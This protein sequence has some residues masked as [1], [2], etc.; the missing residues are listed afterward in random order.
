MGAGSLDPVGSWV[1]LRGAVLSPL[2]LLALSQL[3]PGSVELQPGSARPGD[4]VLV[5]VRGAHAEPRG[6]LG[7]DTLDFFE[8]HGTWVA[9]AALRLETGPGPL[10]LKV[11]AVFLE[12]EVDVVGALD[13]VPPE[14]RRRELTVAPKFIH[15][16][17]AQR[18]WMKEDQLA[19]KE[20]FDVDLSPPKFA[21]DF[22]WPR[23]ADV[24]APFG[25]LR[26]YNG[27]KTSQHY[28]T[29]INGDTGDPIV[30]SN[31]GVVVMK[32][33]CYGSG[34]TVLLS[35]GLGLFTAYFHLSRFDVEHGDKVKRG[36][37]LGLV[38]KTGRVTG[39][40]LHF[41]SKLDGRWVD[42]ESLLR[43]KWPVAQAP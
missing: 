16:T 24:T 10:P 31:D 17:K 14:F 23:L 38:G 30:A 37:Q 40:H 20:A 6:T 27:K 15:P 11:T 36:Q 32:R 29:D 5:V 22:E 42:A 19:F 1:T 9:L 33:E 34:N 3:H 7:P 39:P 2:V 21:L 26:L 12:Q 43:L 18:K 28:G 8:L 4:A 35:H 25:D 41:G 13:V